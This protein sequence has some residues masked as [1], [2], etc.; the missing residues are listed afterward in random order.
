MK[1][2]TSITYH[3][4]AIANIQV[5][6]DKQTDRLQGI[7]TS[8]YRVQLQDRNIVGKGENAGNQHFLLFPQA[9]YPIKLKFRHLGNLCSHNPLPHNVPF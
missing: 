1:H 9:F 3:S 8:S 7:H 6:E 2:K 5:F 4:K